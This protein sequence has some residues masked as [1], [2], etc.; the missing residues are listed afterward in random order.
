M[1]SLIYVGPFVKV[2]YWLCSLVNK[3][4]KC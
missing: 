4:F 3:W 2:C 1:I